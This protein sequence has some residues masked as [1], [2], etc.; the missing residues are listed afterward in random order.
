[1]FS[2]LKI[3]NGCC[4]RTRSRV[5]RSSKHLSKTTSNPLTLVDHLLYADPF[6]F[7]ISII[8]QTEFQSKFKP[9]SHIFII[10][11]CWK[12]TLKCQAKLFKFGSMQSKKYFWHLVFDEWNTFSKYTTY[13]FYR[14]IRISFACKRFPFL[15]FA[16]S[17][18]QRSQVTAINSHEKC[19]FMILLLRFG[20]LCKFIF[21]EGKN[22]LPLLSNRKKPYK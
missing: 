2:Y 3:L 10:F 13:I 4:F 21:T 6:S 22:V 19:R 16:K 20:Q 7:L 8:L 1:M 12:K 14:S 17:P 11:H 15:S 9:T 18:Q 5:Y